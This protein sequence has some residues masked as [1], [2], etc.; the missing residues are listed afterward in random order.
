[1]KIDLK[2]QISFFVNIA[3]GSF[4]V[5]IPLLVNE[6]GGKNLTVGIVIASFYVASL[7][8]YT[9]FG[10]Y[11]DLRAIR[12][13]I[14]IAG[15]FLV[16][17]AV[18]LHYFATG[19]NSL[20]AIRL[21]YGFA[22]GIY[23]GPLLAYTASG[24]EYRS[25]VS[26]FYGFGSLGWAIGFFAGT[27]LLKFFEYQTVFALFSI[28]AFVA[29]LIS[30]RIEKEKLSS[31]TVPVLPVAL[32]RKNLAVYLSFFVRHAAAQA[33]FAFLPIYL[34]FL[35]AP[36]TI[37]GPILALNPLVQFFVMSSI[38]KLKWSSRTIYRAGLVLSAVAFF[39]VAFSPT[40]YFILVPMAII[41]FAWAFLLVGS[42]LILV[43]N[44]VE[45]ATVTGLF[46]ST[47]SLAL[48]IGPLL[49]G[50]LTGAF[51]LRM[52]ILVISFI[53]LSSFFVE[54]LLVKNA[55]KR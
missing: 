21:F 22:A 35:G 46:W 7:M 5:L 18:A 50:A 23:M 14:I 38:P 39:V 15:L 34:L 31:V 27:Y 47:S 42:N 33:V 2:N 12:K 10:R 52:M 1:M 8:S 9:F 45:K 29:F 16:T 30:T 25:N 6:L 49:G 24:N 36:L 26:F 48:I 20:L 11:S 54:L 3:V 32:I 51:G 37:V 41:G 28:P 19:I 40:Y 55:V 17:I 4:F 44:N 43:E 53:A 13:A